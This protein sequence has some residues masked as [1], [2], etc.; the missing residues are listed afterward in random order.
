MRGM[1]TKKQ[2]R[3]ARPVTEPPGIHD[4]GR[5]LSDDSARGW[6][7]FRAKTS[8]R[9]VN[10][11]IGHGEGREKVTCINCVVLMLP[12]YTREDGSL[13]ANACPLSPA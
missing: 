12:V 8:E 7:I 6:T 13:K 11:P 10:R 1:S 9:L 5:N 2:G 3:T 4:S